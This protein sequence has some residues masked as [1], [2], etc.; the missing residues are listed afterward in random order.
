M[1][2]DQRFEKVRELILAL[3]RR[4]DQMIALAALDLKFAV[5]TRPTNWI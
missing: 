2:F 5:K 3:R 1:T 4:Q